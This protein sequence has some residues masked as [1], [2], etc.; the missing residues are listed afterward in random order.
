MSKIAVVGASGY[1]GGNITDEALSRGIEVIGFNRKA[2]T[3]SAPGFTSRIGSLADIEAVKELAAEVSTVVIAVRA[4]EDDVAFLPPLV[5]SILEAVGASGA[6]VGFIG[7]AGSLLVRPNG[8]RHLDSPDFP[9]EYKFEA[10]S[11][12]LVYEMLKNSKTTTDWFYVSPPAGF[13]GYAPGVRTGKFRVGDDILL[14]DENGKSY[15][16]GA[17]FAIAVVDEIASPKHHQKRFTV[18]Y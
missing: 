14:S 9:E 15:I 4:A 12:A 6:R 11:H 3:R 17:D 1:A 10:S 8:P 13:G 2:S 18:A 7:G 16:S 5:S